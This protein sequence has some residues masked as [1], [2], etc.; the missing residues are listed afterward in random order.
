M[1][2]ALLAGMKQ[3]RIALVLFSLANGCALAQGDGGPDPQPVE[4]AD[5][6]ATGTIDFADPETDDPDP[7]VHS[8]AFEPLEPAIGPT[9]DP[10]VEPA[11]P[12]GPVEKALAKPNEYFKR[13]VYHPKWNPDGPLFSGNCAP[14]S[15][16]MIA[17]VFS[18]EPAGLSI[19][20]S[21]VRVRKLMDKWSDSGG[22]TLDQLRLGATRLGLKWR[23]MTASDLDFELGK[24]HMV[25]MT[26]NPG[27]DGSTTRSAYQKAFIA[28]GYAYTWSGKHSIAIFGKLATG[29]YL[30]ADPLS[31]IG[32]IT[33]TSAEMHDFWKRW[34][35]AGT[36]LWLAS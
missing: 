29:H 27:I 19:Q 14:T 4:A 35:G 13:Q 8:L 3:L 6:Q 36:A 15:L 1:A 34:G 30:V 10:P 9:L 20:E 17:E 12:L 23:A 7:S 5:D 28:R 18:K 31:K 33:L 24:K 22:A 32:T 16:A 2:V 26:G 11:P 25:A 21:I